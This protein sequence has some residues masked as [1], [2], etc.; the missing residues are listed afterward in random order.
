MT[1]DNHENDPMKYDAL[2]VFKPFC[3]RISEFHYETSMALQIEAG[4]AGRR[5][6]D[7]VQCMYYM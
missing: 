4:S 7:M 6:T 5:S 3:N 1:C 2:E